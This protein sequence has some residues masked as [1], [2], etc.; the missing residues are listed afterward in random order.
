MLCAFI[1]ALDAAESAVS[2][3]TGFPYP[4]FTIVQ[5]LVYVGIGF[6]LRRRGWNVGRTL[7]AAAITALAEATLGWIVSI[8]IRQ[9]V[10]APN[11]VELVVTVPFVV[12]IEA[13]FAAAGFGLGSLGQRTG[14]R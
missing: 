4:W 8:L 14:A 11:I 2:R 3:A 10:A 13:A 5:I 12:V 9:P 1:V 7:T 6:V